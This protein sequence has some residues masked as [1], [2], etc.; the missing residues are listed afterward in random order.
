RPVPPAA[1]ASSAG[2]SPPAALDVRFPETVVSEDTTGGANQTLRDLSAAIGGGFAVVWQDQRDGL[3]GVEARRISPTGEPAEPE[4]PAHDCVSGRS[5][6]PVVAVA[7]D[8]SGA[9][10]W[11]SARS[12]LEP[13]V[14]LRPFDAHGRFIVPAR[15]VDVAHSAPRGAARGGASRP[16][17]VR[18]RE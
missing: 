10:A 2:R 14:W 12:Y 7:P 17:I 3:L 1:E 18:K 11:I 15:P 13:R 16:A 9:V 6:D 5:L 4:Q 8:G